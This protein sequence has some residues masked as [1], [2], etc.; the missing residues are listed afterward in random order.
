MAARVVLA[1]RRV[2]AVKPRNLVMSA[3]APVNALDELDECWRDA[4]GSAAV[5]ASSECV[6]S[7]WSRNE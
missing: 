2:A 5:R 4:P 3:G 1:R 6:K 7:A